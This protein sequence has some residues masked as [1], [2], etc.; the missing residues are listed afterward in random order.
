MYKT[1]Y[2]LRISLLIKIW[3]HLLKDFGGNLEDIKAASIIENLD[4]DEVTQL[5][6]TK[7]K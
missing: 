5:H 7:Y 3:F 2:L 4:I 1:L 6:L